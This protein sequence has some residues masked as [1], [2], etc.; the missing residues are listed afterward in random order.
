MR[1]NISRASLYLRSH[2]R[3]G[4]HVSNTPL[5]RQRGYSDCAQVLGH[6][7]TP[8][9]KGIDLRPDMLLEIYT[10]RVLQPA[11]VEVDRIVHA[12]TGDVYVAT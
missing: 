5:F 8:P 3:N 11:D 10:M 12:R 6:A 4:Q 2:E 1:L 9:T 7:S